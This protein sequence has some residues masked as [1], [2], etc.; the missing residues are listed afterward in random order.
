MPSR[1][2][3]TSWLTAGPS[4]CCNCERVQAVSISDAAKS[5]GAVPLCVNIL[6][7]ACIQKLQSGCPID[8]LIPLSN[9]VWAIVQIV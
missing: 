5:D 9:L 1:A 7:T 8:P 2:A 6:N 4:H 3:K